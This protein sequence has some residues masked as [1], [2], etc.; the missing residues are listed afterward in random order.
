MLEHA[1][2]ATRIPVRDLATA[3]AWYADKLELEP[4]EERPGGL[5]YT[6]ASGEF[7][8]FESGGK[9]SGTHT[10]MAFEVEDFD[11]A[12]AE[13]EARGVS[14]DEFGIEEVP[15]NYPSKRAKGEKAAWFRD[16]DGNLFGL[17]APLR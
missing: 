1:R 4:V 16:P 13:L 2:V 14:F 3:R 10:Q 12:V 17:G 15:G 5:R 6:C 8:L 11:A 9:A 7:A